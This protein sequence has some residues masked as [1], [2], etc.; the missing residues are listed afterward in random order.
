MKDGVRIAAFAS[1]PI[2][3]K[4]KDTLLVGIIGRKSIIEGVVSDR[5]GV[6]GINSTNSIYKKIHNSRFSEQIRIIALN[7]IALAGL[8]IVDVG[9]LERRLKINTIIVT[10]R[11]PNKKKLIHAINSFKNSNGIDIGYQKNILSKY[12]RKPK[13][14]LGFYV[15][16]GIDPIELKNL[17]EPTVELLR[18]AHIVARGV[19]TGES[20][21]RI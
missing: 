6:N 21:G 2:S 13:R 16:S 18:L 7:G 5:I 8:N 12:K 15:E 9:F 10:R 17:I 1:G 3:K 11:K 4:R 14:M 20:K 19:S